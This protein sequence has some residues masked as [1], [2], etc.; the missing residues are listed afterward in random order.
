MADLTRP[1]RW[2]DLTTERRIV[3]EFLAEPCWSRAA[4]KAKLSDID[5]DV[6]AGSTTIIEGLPAL[7]DRALAAGLDRETIEALAGAVPA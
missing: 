5:P 4:L 2:H 1:R 3:H 7:I 6:I